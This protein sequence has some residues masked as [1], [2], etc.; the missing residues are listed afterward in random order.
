ML[1]MS[2][3]TYIT[4]ECGYIHKIVKQK[5]TINKIKQSRQIFD[6]FVG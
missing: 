6:T 2:F 3:R 1:K 4:I 5:K